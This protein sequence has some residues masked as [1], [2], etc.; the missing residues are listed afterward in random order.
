MLFFFSFN[1]FCFCA[2]T[3]ARQGE[4]YGSAFEETRQRAH[5]FAADTSFLSGPN[6]VRGDALGVVFYV[7]TS[8]KVVGFG[9]ADTVTKIDLWIYGARSCDQFSINVTLKP[10]KECSKDEKLY[11]GLLNKGAV[12]GCWNLLNERDPPVGIQRCFRRGFVFFHSV[13]GGGIP[14]TSCCFYG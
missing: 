2:I 3:E 12:R 8:K 6:G 4:L 5:G 14:V 9:S 7:D 10:K 1:N 13:R 11:P